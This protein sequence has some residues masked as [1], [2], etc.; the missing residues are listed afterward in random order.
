MDASINADPAL[1]KHSLPG[2]SLIPPELER[3]TQARKNRYGVSSDNGFDEM[4]RRQAGLAGE[5]L[6]GEQETALNF[7]N[8]A[9]PSPPKAKAVLPPKVNKKGRKIINEP[10]ADSAFNPSRG[11]QPVAGMMNI[12]EEAHRQKLEEDKRRYKAAVEIQRRARGWKDRKTTRK[13]RERLRADIEEDHR[14]FTDKYKHYDGYN[15]ERFYSQ[16]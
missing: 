5:D 8:E 6:P 1:T 12:K 13:L 2:N 16:R 9:A 4:A 11:R 3:A 15:L 10:V 14:A 7:T